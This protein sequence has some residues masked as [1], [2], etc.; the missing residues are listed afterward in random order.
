MVFI[1]SLFVPHLSLFWCP[2]Q[3]P[4]I[5]KRANLRP[6]HKSGPKPDPSNYRPV[7]I[8]PILSKI[9]EKCITKYLFAFLNKYPTLKIAVRISKRTFLQHDSNQSGHRRSKLTMSLVNV[10]FKL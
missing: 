8:I 1:L 10:S 9:I 2:G 4:D 3:F 6:I 7:S 5:L